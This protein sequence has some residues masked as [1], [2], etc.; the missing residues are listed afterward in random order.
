MKLIQFTALILVVG[1]IVAIMSYQK[2]ISK[3]LLPQYIDWAYETDKQGLESGSPLNPQELSLAKNIGIQNPEK[4][5]I[6]YVD[7]VPFPYEN[8]ALKTLG[9]ALGFIGE[10]IINNAQVFGYSIYVRNGYE[11]NRP[12]LAHELVHV[13]QI[14]RTSLDHIITKHFSDLAEY[15]YDKAPLEVEAFK[16]NKEYAS[17]W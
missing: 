2:V 11:L 9:E 5:R 12:K 17:D 15:G 3:I 1:I 6:V 13:L 8:F 14:E 4:V 10:G 7:E 16:A